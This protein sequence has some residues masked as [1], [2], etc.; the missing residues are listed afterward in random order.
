MAANSSRRK[1]NGKR[2]KGGSV[3]EVY[4][5]LH[6]E[7]LTLRVEPG[8][9]LDEKALAERFKL[10]RSPVREALIRLAG[11]GLVVAL[12]NRSTLVAPFDLTAFP[13]YVEALGLLQRANTR[14]A[15]QLR[16]EADIEKIRDSQRNFVEAVHSN[17]HL[18]MSATNKG[19]HIA[20]AVAGKNPYLTNQYGRL[21][22][23]GR[24]MLHLHFD[25]LSK[26]VEEDLLTDE[27][28]EMFQAIVDQD[29]ERADALAHLHTRQFRDRFFQFMQQNYSENMPIT[30]TG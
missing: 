1:P 2:V 22:D 8:A 25:Y 19:F 24:R 7:I 23:E 21:L 17:D 18:R 11:E 3:R 20:I 4:E 26:S 30:P 13:K 27:H 15:A 29:V 12:S 9:P 28:D 14:L 5:T 16:S 10:S 6:H